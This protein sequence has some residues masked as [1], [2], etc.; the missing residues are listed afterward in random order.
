MHRIGNRFE[1]L[2]VDEAHHFGGGLKDEALEMATAPSRLGLTATPPELRHARAGL[3]ELIGPK[4]F[5]LSV[6]DLAGSYLA[7]FDLVKLFVELTPDERRSH[8]G[9]VALYREP[10][11]EFRRLNPAASWESFLRTAARSGGGARYRRL[12]SRAA[13]SRLPRGQTPSPPVS[14]RAAPGFSG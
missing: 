14:S 5:E 9:W 6:A 13:S 10:L 2:V 12:D 1:L 8:E 7:P 11:A 4:V 3:R